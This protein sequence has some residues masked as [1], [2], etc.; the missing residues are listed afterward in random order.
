MSVRMLETHIFAVPLCSTPSLFLYPQNKRTRRIRNTH[1]LHLSTTTIILTRGA[2]VY[3]ARHHKFTPLRQLLPWQ[4]EV[5]IGGHHL[6]ILVGIPLTGTLRLLVDNHRN[7]SNKG[8]DND[9]HH[10]GDDDGL[11]LT[12]VVIILGGRG[13]HC[14]GS[15]HTQ[16]REVA[17]VGLGNGSIGGGGVLEAEH[18]SATSIAQS[19]AVE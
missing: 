16:E 6:L 17:T 13:V 3:Q 11:L 14:A 9:R 19:S 18:H 1:H 4:S 8:N 5:R 2:C 12:V 10:N 7:N 15:G